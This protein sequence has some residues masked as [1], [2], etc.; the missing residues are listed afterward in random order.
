MK[1][2]TLISLSKS[3]AHTMSVWQG[4]YRFDI[5][6]VSTPRILGVQHRE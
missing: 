6:N 5:N 1:T 2:A 4:E 3:D